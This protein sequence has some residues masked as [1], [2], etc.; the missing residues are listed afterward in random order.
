MGI[1]VSILGNKLKTDDFL[2]IINRHDILAVVETHTSYE[3]ELNI[4]NFKHFVKC[5]E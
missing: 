1:I 5:R 4:T 3:A 2:D